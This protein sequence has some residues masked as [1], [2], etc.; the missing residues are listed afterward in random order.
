MIFFVILIF[1]PSSFLSSWKR[2]KFAPPPKHL[3]RG[4]SVVVSA[5]FRVVFGL[6]SDVAP[7]P[8][9]G[10]AR[11]YNFDIS[12]ESNQRNKFVKCFEHYFSGRKFIVYVQL[13][14]LLVL[15][16]WRTK[17]F[18]ADTL[19]PPCLDKMRLKYLILRR[20]REMR[21]KRCAIRKKL[22]VMVRC[23]GAEGSA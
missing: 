16:L 8:I 19:S 7:S 10:T 4:V 3:Q 2:K 1:N 11:K 12:G 14:A 9:S 5:P 17:R 21:L 13:S 6:I 18:F 15:P 22:H 20:R 23:R